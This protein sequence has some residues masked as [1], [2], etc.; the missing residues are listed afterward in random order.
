MQENRDDKCGRCG[1]LGGKNVIVFDPE[2]VDIDAAVMFVT[3]TDVCV[4][5]VDIPIYSI[6]TSP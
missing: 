5:S 4:S 2:V 1:S 3:V 6:G